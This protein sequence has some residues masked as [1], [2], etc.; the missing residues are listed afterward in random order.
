MVDSGFI[1]DYETT[2][3]VIR[4]AAKTCQKFGKEDSSE[5]ALSMR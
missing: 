2:Q 4:T 3:K 5:F 1:D